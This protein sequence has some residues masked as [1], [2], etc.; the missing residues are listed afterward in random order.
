ML[1]NK[2][3]LFVAEAAC[4]LNYSSHKIYSMIHSGEL[5]AYKI[6]GHKR[7]YIPEESIKAHVTAMMRRYAP[8]Q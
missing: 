4:V 8:V 3:V 1:I 6:P 7:W 2:T 5:S